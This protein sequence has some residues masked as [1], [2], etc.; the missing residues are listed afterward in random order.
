MKKT[1]VPFQQV[2]QLAKTDVAYATGDVKLEPF[3]AYPPKLS[4]FEA[5]IA[6]KH[7]ATYP[8]TDL[9]QVL[10]LQYADLHLKQSVVT[11]IEALR[12]E[13]TFTVT[14]AHQPSLF[15][16]PLYFIYKALTTINLAAEI[17][18]QS[19]GAYQVVPVF[20]LGSDDHD[21]EELNKVNLFGKKIVWE[22]GLTGP[23]GA[24]DVA[25]VN[26]ALEELQNIL[27]QSPEAQALYERVSAAYSGGRTF[28]A[29]T[30]ALL[31]EFLGDFGL[32]VLD[33]NTAVLKRHF[34]PIMQQE[35]LEQPSASIVNSTITQLNMAG[36]K[37]QAAPRDINL[38]YMKPGLRERIVLEAG[39]YKVL[40]TEMVFSTEAILAE[41]AAHPER[42]SPNVVLRPLYQE[43]VLPNLAYVGGGGELA[44]WLERKALFAHFGV[45]YP[46][47]V[48]RNSVLWLDKDAVKKLEKF[49]FAMASFFGETEALVREYVEKNAVVDVSLASEIKELHAIYDKIAHKA[50]A[51]DPTL[52]K[53]V[54]AEEVK[55]AG[56]LEQWESRLLRAEKQRH[57]VTIN[58]L[59]G[60]KEKLFPANGLQER[61]D[62]ILPYL[63]K[64]GEVFLTE[65]KSTLNPFDS[66][67]IVLQTEEVS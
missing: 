41:L 42:F 38:F 60:L 15:L 7:G 34:I 25:T 63:L 6:A 8:R 23:V 44:Y 58:Q 10:Q 64:Y 66:G 29:A 55:A 62:N 24:M 51:I 47:L 36:F 26:P 32:V 9:V 54:R 21:L 65:L 56:G 39:V 2:P 27:G 17:Q 14:T 67:F 30:Q 57:E 13:N 49:G 11:N 28:A 19:G 48:R 20:V 18:Q 43:L 22:P 37:T 12:L 52:E 40:N 45:Q 31:H 61:S 53:A 3:V 50:S 16:G 1:L 33:M 46:M 4:A 5:V 59:R 35:L